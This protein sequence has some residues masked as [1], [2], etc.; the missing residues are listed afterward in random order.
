MR[1]PTKNSRVWILAAEMSGF[2]GR[3][4]LIGA[5]KLMAW[6]KVKTAIV[7]SAFVL[8]VGTTTVTLCYLE[9]SVRGIPA[10]W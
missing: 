10:I 5:F 3:W 2:F 9:R 1:E 7:I 6:A 8:A 4:R